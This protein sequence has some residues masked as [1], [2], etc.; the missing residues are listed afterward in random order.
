MSGKREKALRR[1][2]AVLPK[3]ECTYCRAA[4]GAEGDHVF[5]AAWYPTTTPPEVQRLK[6]PSCRACNQRWHQVEDKLA[7]DLV[8]VVDPTLPEMAGVAERYL[9]GLRPDVARDVSDAR[10]R[11]AKALKSLHTMKWVPGVPG[12]PLV[13]MRL[14][15][16]L[17]VRLSPARELNNVLLRE[18]S[19][20]LIRGLTYKET[21]EL[22]G[23]VRVDAVLWNEERE[24][25]MPEAS[26]VLQSDP[27]DSSLGPGFWY[28]RHV[29]PKISAW[30]F[31]IWGQITIVAFC[32]PADVGDT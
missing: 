14:L 30:A 28:R 1:A 26:L 25:Q 13:P 6:V 4:P 8:M 23:P 2:E 31:R 22:L 16:G 3:A 9:R 19:E 29:E 10:H 5:P 32:R 12:K 24:T 7:A 11:A 27:I 18:F 20:K 15:S 21:G 17:L